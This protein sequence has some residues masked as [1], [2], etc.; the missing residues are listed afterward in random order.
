[1]SGS[2]G[3]NLNTQEVVFTSQAA[4]ARVLHYWL[5]DIVS[6]RTRLHW[7]T[8]C[9][10]LSLVAVSPGIAYL[11]ISFPEI[12][13]DQ[14]RVYILGILLLLI[15]SFVYLVAGRLFLTFASRALPNIIA[16]L[17]PDKLFAPMSGWADR[18]RFRSQL[19]LTFGIGA[20]NAAANYFTIIL[21][22][23]GTPGGLIATALSGFIVGAIAGNVVHLYAHFLAIIPALLSGKVRLNTLFPRETP[24]LRALFR[25]VVQFTVIYSVSNAIVL[26]AIFVY[27][28]VAS[29]FRIETISLVGAFNVALTW[30]V[31][32]I[33]IGESLPSIGRVISE[34]K[35]QSL[36]SLQDMID[37]KY[38]LLY[39]AESSKD[40]ATDIEKLIALHEAV[41]G[42][43]NL[44]FDF[45]TITRFA[46]SFLL[47]LL[48]LILNLIFN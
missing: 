17:V 30:A 26:T 33:G 20:I 18:F 32:A 34:Q 9:V 24:G 28:G 31:A 40:L 11:A 46:A 12:S 2:R 44:P 23:A 45:E 13:T 25:L 5:I 43:P 8:V 48:P 4:V 3:E 15:A 37:A 27:V 38:A 39:A 22:G 7:L 16:S 19:Y 14:T 36:A 41:K 21:L 42:Q 29:S 1:M 10:L 47:P 6:K 35:E